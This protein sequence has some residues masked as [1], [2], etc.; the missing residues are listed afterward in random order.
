MKAIDKIRNYIRK[1]MKDGMLC[2]GDRLPSLRSIA[3][4]TG[5]CYMTARSAIVTLGQEGIVDIKSRG[6]TFVS[7]AKPLKVCLNVVPTNV[8]I[9]DMHRLMEKYLAKANLHLELDIRPVE[10]MADPAVRGSIQK[11]FKAAVSIR[12]HMLTFDD[13]P[14][15]PLHLF[16]DYRKTAAPLERY[17]QMPG[18]DSLPFAFSTYQIGVNRKLLAKAGFKPENLSSDLLWWDQYAEAA[19]KAGFEP[20]STEWSEGISASINNIVGPLLSLIPFDEKRYSGGQ[21]LFATPEGQRFLRIIRDFYYRGSDDMDP[22]SFQQNGAGLHFSIGS[23]ITAQNRNPARPDKAVDDL[24]I[25]PYRNFIFYG[26]WDLSSYMRHDLS[27]EERNRIWALM[28]LM[29]SKEFQLDYC[30]RS[31]LISCRN[32]LEPTE[33]LWNRSGK[34]ME[35]FPAPDTRMIAKESIFP[36]FSLYALTSLLE[37]YL[38]YGENPEITAQRMDVKKKFYT[39]TIPENVLN[40]KKET[41]K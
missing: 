19:R 16:P 21:P 7:G 34:W 37:N 8:S 20:A 14:H 5:T 24:L 27:A 1:Q 33:Y 39:I 32:D 25:L 3:E 17:W 23:W 18:E 30:G 29:V 11:N 13:L 22:K 12:P 28:K 6:G 35:F 41:G 31:G 40:T 2:P 15:T 38:F 4:K 9:P 10:Y 26:G 36:A